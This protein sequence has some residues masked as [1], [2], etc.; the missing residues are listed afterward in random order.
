M[1]LKT[2]YRPPDTVPQTPE[3]LCTRLRTSILRRGA[4]IVLCFFIS[5][6]NSSAVSFSCKQ[7]SEFMLTSL[8][9]R[10]TGGLMFY[11]RRGGVSLQTQGLF[12]KWFSFHLGDARA[13]TLNLKGVMSHRLQRGGR[14]V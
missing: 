13:R 4:K 10:N 6:F 14:G 3:G 7:I 11:R 1:N 8:L 2:F 9:K 12:A 5:V